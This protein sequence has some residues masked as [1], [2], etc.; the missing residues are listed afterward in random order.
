M[1]FDFIGTVEIFSSLLF[2]LS[3]DLQGLTLDDVE[4]FMLWIMYDIAFFLQIQLLIYID[5]QSYRYHK[6]KIDWRC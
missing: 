2:K 3:V 5:K 6:S 4:I 1:A